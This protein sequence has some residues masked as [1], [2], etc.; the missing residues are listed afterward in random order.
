[1]TIFDAARGAFDA[2]YGDC[3][4]NHCRR[5]GTETV[6]AGLEVPGGWSSARRLAEGLYGGKAIINVSQQ[7]LG[8]EQV[9]TVEVLCDD[10]V[11]A[12]ESFTPRDGLLG[13]R[14]E[15]G[16]WALAYR[17]GPGTAEGN[18]V[19]AGPA[20]LCAAVVRTASAMGRAAA[21]LL[22]QGVAAEELLWGWSC[23]PVTLPSLDESEVRAAH[24]VEMAA[25]GVCSIW[26]RSERPDWERLAGGWAAFRLRLHCLESGKT[27]GA[28]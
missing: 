3:P 2:I 8:G 16:R 22:E 17:E 5:E 15:S 10:P 13:L 12:S 23:G 14:E 7:K 11:L 9:P 24:Q 18:L 21:W 27:Y 6:D 19:L 20:S 28:Q 26:V 4:A 25:H 1:M